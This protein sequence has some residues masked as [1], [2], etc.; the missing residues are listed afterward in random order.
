VV[1]DA[2][3]GIYRFRGAE[4]NAFEEMARRVTAR[5]LPA[6]R[7]F[8]LTRNFRSGPRLLDSLHPF[9]RRWGGA[10]LLPY[11]ESD[12]LRPQPRA[13]D[14]SRPVHL[15]TGRSN[16][17]ATEAASRVARWRA[18]H[19]GTSVGILGRQNWQAVKGQ[20]EVRRLDLACELRVGGSF[21]ESPAVRE[22]RVLLEAVADPFD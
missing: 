11:V 9:F 14:S 20:E 7:E 10:Q 17:V 4:G 15:E 13:D 8:P 1:G 3:Q 2:K 21:F 6:L 18:R 19:P 12:R 16:D 5:G 22:L